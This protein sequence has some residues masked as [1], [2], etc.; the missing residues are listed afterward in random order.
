MNSQAAQHLLEE[1]EEEY[2][3]HRVLPLYMFAWSLAGLGHDRTD[4]AF[5]RICREA[6]DHFVQTHAGVQLVEVPWP[7]DL[8]F[9]KPLPAETSLVLDLDPE[10]PRETWLQAL[11]HPDELAA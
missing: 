6:Y 4:P 7:I 5:E 1:V 2:S 8:T 3:F 10:S 11:V 9:A